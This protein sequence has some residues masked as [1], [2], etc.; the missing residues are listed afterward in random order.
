MMNQLELLKINVNDKTEKKNGM[1]YLSWAWAWT[2]VL[3][4]D[5]AATYEVK[6]WDDGT[7]LGKTPVMSIGD[8]GM[9]WVETTVFGKSLTCQLPI[10]DY[11]NK[12]ISHPDA[13][14]VNTAIMRCLVKSLALH[15]LGLYIYSGED[16]PPE[17]EV[18]TVT[19]ATPTATL[20]MTVPAS[21]PIPAKVETDGASVSA[22]ETPKGD[23][24]DED[25]KKIGDTMI[26]FISVHRDLPDLNSYWKKNQVVLDR[27][28]VSHPE[29]Y[30]NVRN[31][32]A[33]YKKTLQGAEK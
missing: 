29:I 18:K 23:W 32:F 12:P 27:L 5:Q 8:T 13:M 11:R 4:A 7:G 14:A 20:E 22:V 24:T 33:E 9:V 3:K 31:G 26:A 2:E 19:V 6:L 21:A 15:G 16:T 1:T 25:A 30:A 17:E 28:K 10:L